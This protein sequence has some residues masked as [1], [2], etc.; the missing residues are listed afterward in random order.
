MRRVELDA[1]TS[2][3]VLSQVTMSGSSSKFGASH[4]WS[5]S[6]SAGMN[7]LLGLMLPDGARVESVEF[8]LASVGAA[9][10]R[11]LME[12]RAGGGIVAAVAEGLDMLADSTESAAATVSLSGGRDSGR[13]DRSRAGVLTLAVMGT[14]VVPLVIKV[15]SASTPFSS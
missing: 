6:S 4:C 1:D 15:N 12:V 3:A 5:S 13:I 8:D 14:F 9:E 10:S 7:R 2:S 11:S